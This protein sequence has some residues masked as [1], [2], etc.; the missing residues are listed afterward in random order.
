MGIWNSPINI[1]S[2]EG[3]LKKN[4]LTIYSK[5]LLRKIENRKYRYRGYHVISPPPFCQN[6]SYKRG[7]TCS[8]TGDLSENITIMAKEHKFSQNY[9]KN[10]RNIWL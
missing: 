10:L 7:G 1:L 6:L 3:N 2:Y 5:N 9:P 8:A 4:L